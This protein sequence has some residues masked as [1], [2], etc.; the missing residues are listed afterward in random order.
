MSRG[1]TIAPGDEQFVIPIGTRVRI[2]Q[3]DTLPWNVG[4]IAVVTGYDVS[5]SHPLVTTIT[6]LHLEI[7]GEATWKH[8]KMPPWMVE[9]VV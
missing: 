6:R 2:K 1:Y 3:D 7:E 8:P 5:Q 9:R 4:R